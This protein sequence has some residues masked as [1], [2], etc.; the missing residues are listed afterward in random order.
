MLRH[1]SLLCVWIFFLA[2]ANAQ[3]Q[4]EFDHYIEAIAKKDSVPGASFLVVK[5]GKIVKSATYGFSNLELNAPARQESVW[6]LASVSKPITA[7]AVMKL[8]EER[9]IHLDS[10]LYSYLGEVVTERYRKVT[11][12]QIMSHTG[13]IPSDHFIHTK[14]YA[15]T[16][17]RYTVKEQLN[18]LFKMPP[19]G[20]PGE[21]FVYSNASFFLQAVIIEKVTGET[22]QQFE[23][24]AIFDKAGMKHSYFLNGDSLIYNRAQVYTKR[25]GTWVRFSLETTLQS[26]DANGFGGLMYTTG[27]LNLFVQALL[28]GKIISKASVQQMFTITK[29][30][31][32]TL[33]PVREVDQK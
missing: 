28:A 19:A 33:R 14:L 2:T 4:D 7:T 18:D 9:K 24:R 16:P 26:L 20:K 5:K 3:K 10:T 21:Q 23:Q 29:L 30:N 6:E 8:V 25:K 13:S 32:G 11:V 22:Y 12:R 15:P 31:D 17:L 27:D 1:F